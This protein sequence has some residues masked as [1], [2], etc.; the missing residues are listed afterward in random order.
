M[1]PDAGAVSLKECQ[2]LRSWV[3]V[4]WILAWSIKSHAQFDIPVDTWRTHNSYNTLISLTASN[5]KIYAAN[6]NALFIFEPSNQETTIITSLTGLNDTEITTIAYN[7]E[8]EALIITYGNGNI[9]ILANNKIT[10]FPA[11]LLADISGSKKVNHIS[12]YRNFSYLSTDFGVLILDLDN[13][14][15]KETLFE[16]GPLGQKIKI[17][18]STVESDSLYLATEL[19]VMR[20]SLQDNLK[21]FNRWLFFDAADGLP[22]S[23]TRVLL[24]T[25]NGLL[26]AVD[27]VGIY[28]YN[29]SSW[30]NKN[31]LKQSQFVFG[32]QNGDTS[33]LTTTDTVYQYI[34]NSVQPVATNF[35]RN[36]KASISMDNKIWIA[37]NRNGLVDTQQEISIYPNGPLQNNVV[38]LINYEDVIIGLPPA[39][40]NFFL[41]LRNDD[42]YFM[43]YKGSWQ[44]FNSTGNPH[45]NLIPEFY[46]I[47]GATYSTETKSLFLSS[48]GY[49]I[50]KV[51]DQGSEIIDENTPGSPLINTNPPARNVLIA[52]LT[53]NSNNL[54]AINFSALQPLHQNDLAANT[55][56][57]YTPS[58]PAAK[59]TQII[60]VGNGILWMK[61]AHIFGGGVKVYDVNNQRELYLTSSE[62]S[63][64]LP[65]HNVL[66]IALDQEGKMWVATENGV[67]YYYSA[68]NIFET[69]DLNPV[70]P[71]FDGQVLFKNEQVSALA[72]DGGNRIWMATSSGLWLFANDGSEVIS[73]FT[74]DT[75]PLPSNDIIDIAINQAN[76]EIFLATAKGLVSYRGT[77]TSTGQLEEL[78]IFPN[79][80]IATEND[81]VT[82]EGVPEN[83]EVLITDA[84]GR[85]VYKT[86]AN[87]NTAVWQG[88][89]SNQSISSGIYFIFVSNSDGSQK[90]VGKLA[91]IK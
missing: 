69:D 79:P 80:V 67:V 33:L 88:V 34:A 6:S 74:S 81:I 40:D 64:N 62:N 49:G 12:H 1:K 59:A 41:P 90:Q 39:Y 11:M 16:L 37:D 3:L 84:S 83:A 71:V 91:I 87:G 9:D 19:G 24:S 85:L 68:I 28:E 52:D 70:I 50:L 82:I 35:G 73:H 29:G 2:M 44:N 47:S 66:D 42:G 14:Q 30:Q 63:G 36:P 65:D 53:T 25:P 17:Y 57:S 43:F 13:F 27:T 31:L 21:D 15:V 10:N 89:S 23:T 38:R 18:A 86:N 61:I 60:D 46:D 78:K 54:S 76:G 5:S 26:V 55:W 58:A 32:S 45:T 56:R 22:A 72:V 77:S 75:D 7:K 20:G 8:S 4:I 51:T 48:F